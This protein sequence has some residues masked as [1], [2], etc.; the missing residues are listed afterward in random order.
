MRAFAALPVLLLLIHS[1]AMADVTQLWR[2]LGAKRK[3]LTSYHQE[4]DRTV[5]YTLPDQVQA[6]RRSAV[7]DGSGAR[8][9]EHNLS[10]S[11]DWSYLFDGSGFFHLEAG[12]Y[13]SENLAHNKE[14]PEPSPYDQTAVDLKKGVEAKRFPCGLDKVDHECISLEIPVKPKV[15]GSPEAAKVTAGVRQIIV[16]STTGLVLLS[17]TVETYQRPGLS[18]RGVIEVRAKQMS[19]NGAVDPAVFRIPSRYTEVKELSKW[20]AKKMAKELSGKPAPDFAFV[21]MSGKS[22]KLSELRGKTVLLDFWAT[23]CG[24]CRADGPSLDKLAKKYGD[25]RLQIVGVSV[26]EDRAIVRKFLNEHPHGYPIVL[27]T[28]NEMPRAYQI[29]VF[30]TYVII[31]SEGKFADATE[32]DSG[33]S[34]LRKLLK[35]AGMDVE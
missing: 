5:S 20:N 1:F 3:A 30:P 10:G 35:R 28:E 31:D 27:T 34:K 24:P 26:D 14:A 29:G 4:F 8:W 23:W 9:R 18:Y 33:F 6:S 7:L 2:D 19:W 32:G 25:N 15:G 11:G 17:Q 13:T 12:E 21:D 22:I 16:D